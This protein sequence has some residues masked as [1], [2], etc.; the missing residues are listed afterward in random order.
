MPTSRP[1]WWPTVV[2]G[3]GFF[4]VIVPKAAPASSRAWK[5]G[6][7]GKEV[8]V[9]SEFATERQ[10]VCVHRSTAPQLAEGGE[11]S[12]A[13]GGLRAGPEH[14]LYA[15]AACCCIGESLSVASLGFCAERDL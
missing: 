1:G 13:W 14:I 2:C 11:S 6:Q 7:Q 4:L 9:V 10:L 12:K 15:R 3:D 5:A 8:S